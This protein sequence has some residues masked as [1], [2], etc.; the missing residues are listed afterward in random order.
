MGEIRELMIFMLLF[1]GIIIGT[2]IFYSDLFTRYDTPAVKNLASLNKTA[3]IVAKTQQVS[4]QINSTNIQPSL[5]GILGIA[6]G[7]FGAIS[8]M[9][10][11]PNIF[12]NLIGDVVSISTELFMPRW[13]ADMIMGIVSIIIVFAI[14]SVYMKMRA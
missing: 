7:V 10:D 5:S 12:G 3:Q 4:S 1:S 11:M 2:T 9:L 8:L 6:S 14:I 13:F